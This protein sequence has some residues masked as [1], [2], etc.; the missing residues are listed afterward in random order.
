MGPFT[1]FIL[2][3]ALSCLVWLPRSSTEK[4]FN[5][6]VLVGNQAIDKAQVYEIFFNAKTF[7][8]SPVTEKNLVWTSAAF[9]SIS[10]V[11]RVN[12]RGEDAV[13]VTTDN[14]AAVVAYPSGQ[15][16]FSRQ[17]SGANLDI[18]SAEVLPDGNVA[19]ACS[20]TNLLVILS[21]PPS[22]NTTSPQPFDQSVKYSI[23]FAHGVVW[24]KQRKKLLV[25][26]YLNVYIF[27][28]IRPPSNKE[29]IDLK[30]V[31][32]VSFDNFYLSPDHNETAESEDGGHDLYPIDGQTDMLF[33]TTGERVHVFN[34]NTYEITL[35]D[36]LYQL[37]SHNGA[38]SKS[39]AYKSGV[40]G[41]S[42]DADFGLTYLH[43]APWISTDSNYPAS[44]DHLIFSFDKGPC[45]VPDY[46]FTP[47]C[48]INFT[49]LSIYFYKARVFKRP[50][51]SYEEI[52]VPVDY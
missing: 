10:E 4:I 32:T 12:Y 45:A 3:Q 25:L 9:P 16:L 43:A 24:D 22:D 33:L 7:E 50:S 21:P 38:T 41:I 13:L 15:V 52:L 29:L 46:D 20:T 5:S 27:D 2:F 35:H 42:K 1:G 36:S 44:S 30:L 11:K 26:G 48:K 47:A 6:L 18:H 23:P 31:S 34:A 14:G 28:Y 51:F 49:N 17:I 39:I 37:M 40:K 19:L 8:P